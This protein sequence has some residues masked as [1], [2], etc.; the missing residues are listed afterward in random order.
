MCWVLEPQLNLQVW[1]VPCFSSLP[2]LPIHLYVWFTLPT[3]SP[4]AATNSSL[5]LT[6]DP[7][8]SYFFPSAWA[9]VTMTSL[10][11]CILNKHMA[12]RLANAACCLVALGTTDHSA[13]SAP[14]VNPAD[15]SQVAKTNV[16]GFFPKHPFT[17]SQGRWCSAQQTALHPQHCIVSPCPWREIDRVLTLWIV[18]VTTPKNDSLVC[19]PDNLQTLIAGSYKNH[20]LYLPENVKNPSKINMLWVTDSFRNN[21]RV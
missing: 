21:H 8:A 12:S 19:I 7:S 9:T 18:I 11:L 10:S 1:T 16:K 17:N 2:R 5:L 15:P 20:V 6:S 3:E 13:A 4:S 14:G